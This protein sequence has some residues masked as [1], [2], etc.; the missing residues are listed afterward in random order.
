MSLK[1]HLSF[2]WSFRTADFN[3]LRDKYA[4]SQHKARDR[5][6]E[7]EIH[8]V[9]ETDRERFCPDVSIRVITAFSVSVSPPVTKDGVCEV[10]T[11]RTWRMAPD[12]IFRRRGWRRMVE[13]PIW[14]AVPNPRCSVFRPLFFLDE[15]G[16]RLHCRF[17]RNGHQLNVVSLPIQTKGSRASH[18][19]VNDTSPPLF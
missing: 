2:S 14:F 8:S 16:D 11:E 9:R 5:H 17:L 18:R 1:V 7:R 4:D 3:L 15:T 6:N 10:E 13:E 12:G 19:Q